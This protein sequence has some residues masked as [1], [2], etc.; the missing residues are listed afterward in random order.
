MICFIADSESPREPDHSGQ[1]TSSGDKQDTSNRQEQDEDNEYD[2]DSSCEGS[3]NAVH[4]DN[5]GK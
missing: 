3:S 4:Q 5:V 1:G 2:S